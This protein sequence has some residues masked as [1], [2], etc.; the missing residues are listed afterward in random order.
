MLTDLVARGAAAKD[1]DYKLSD[2][3]GLYLSVAATGR[4]TWRWKCRFEDKEHPMVFGAYPEMT[5]KQARVLRDEAKAILRAG[6]DPG[7]EA[8]RG[9]AAAKARSGQTFEKFAR[10]WHEASFERG[11]RARCYSQHGARPPS[12]HWRASDR[13]YR[14]AVAARCLAKS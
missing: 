14:R 11:T 1:K 4:R 7:V 2:G 9:V 13:R 12:S 10:A 5:L 6:R 8:K 3:G